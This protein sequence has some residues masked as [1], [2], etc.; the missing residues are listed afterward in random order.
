MPDHIAYLTLMQDLRETEQ[1]NGHDANIRDI[2]DHM[3]LD[4]E[5][6]ELFLQFMLSSYNQMISTNRAITNRMLCA[7]DKPRYNDTQAYQQIGLS[8]A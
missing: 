5:H 6:A 1:Q 7:G 8:S 4:R 2:Q 3:S